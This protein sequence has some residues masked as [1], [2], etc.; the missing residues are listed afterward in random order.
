MCAR[1]IVHGKWSVTDSVVHCEECTPI[2][3]HCEIGKLVLQ[4]REVVPTFL[5]VQ[6]R[7]IWWIPDTLAHAKKTIAQ[8]LKERRGIPIDL[9]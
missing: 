2:A 1:E 9:E 8:H 6:N 5:Q 3:F 7:L 4:I